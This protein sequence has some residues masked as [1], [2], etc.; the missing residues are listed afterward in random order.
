MSLNATQAQ[1]KSLNGY[2]QSFLFGLII[3]IASSGITS[4]TA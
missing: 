1:L 2:A 3:A 4:G